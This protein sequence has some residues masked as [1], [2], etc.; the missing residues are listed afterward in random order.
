M[1][2]LAALQTLS[3]E[4][5][6]FIGRCLGDRDLSR[7]T[8]T[9]HLFERIF[10]EEMFERSLQDKPPKVVNVPALT[11]AIDFEHASLV[12]RI[13]SQPSFAI[14]HPDL[15]G[16]LHQAAAVGNAEIVSI[17]VDA[18]YGVN[19][20][21]DFDE[22]PLHRCAK[23]GNA[24]A[25]KVLLDHG[26][27][28]DSTDGDDMTAFGLA[29]SSPIHILNKLRESS[30]FVANETQLKYKAESRVVSTLKVLVDNGARPEIFLMNGDGD[31]P[32]HIA[33]AECIGSNDDPDM[34]AGSGV[35]KFL[36][37]QGADLLVRN[38]S[39]LYPIQVAVD[40]LTA[41]R[42]ALN[43]FLNLGMSPNLKDS[44]G[45]SLMSIACQCD[46]DSFAVME[47]LLKRGAHADVTLSDIFDTYEPEPVNFDKILVL[48]LIHGAQFGTDA[49]RCFMFA[50][51]HG[52]LDV[53]KTIYDTGVD[54]NAPVCEL[55]VTVAVTPL[56]CALQEG[57]HD[58]LEFLVKKGVRMSAAEKAQVASILGAGGSK[59]G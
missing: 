21:W 57:R 11:W 1:T 17:L 4:V 26:A 36:V 8:R 39:G 22:T 28:I 23:N 16:A 9:S 49:A 19:A 24:A 42:T 38:H 31:T 59:F 15:Y 6:T 50:A 37:E 54:I 53:M 2:S 3:T 46:V 55:G 41:N 5:L 44:H 32:L 47:L 29:I 30:G 51:R 18:G 43:F 34:V 12:R 27:I 48:L 52:M 35:M 58:M 56:Q 33:V 10:S 13:V 25:A 20:A 40:Y 14:F 7:L 45:D